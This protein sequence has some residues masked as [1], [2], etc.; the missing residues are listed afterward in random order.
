MDEMLKLTRNNKIARVIYFIGLNGAFFFLTLFFS[1]FNNSMMLL[2]QAFLLIF[3][4][5]SLATCL[6]SFWAEAK[7]PDHTFTFGYQRFE[8]L[9][10]FTSSVL[11][12]LSCIFILKESVERL[13]EVEPATTSFMW[14]VSTGALI[15]HIWTLLAVENYPFTHVLERSSTSWLQEHVAEFS[16]R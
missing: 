16:E 12:Q 8:V 11:Y 9:A 5:L 10:L 13:T 6:I 7:Q 1:S 15:V 2:A 4:V 14:L 3:N